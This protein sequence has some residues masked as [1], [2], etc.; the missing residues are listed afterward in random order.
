MLLQ[1]YFVA[2]IWRCQDAFLWIVDMQ[3]YTKLEW[4]EQYD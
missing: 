1:Q 3:A 4:Q 2:I